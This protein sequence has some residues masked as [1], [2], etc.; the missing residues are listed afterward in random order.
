[1]MEL[2][3][4]SRHPGSPD[5]LL[6]TE[7]PQLEQILPNDTSVSHNKTQDLSVHRRTAGVGG[8]GYTRHPVDA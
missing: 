3:T 1:M 8:G 5:W 2:P 4:G 7:T 6:E